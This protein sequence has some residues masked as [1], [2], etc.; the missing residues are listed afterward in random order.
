MNLLNTK[1]LASLWGGILVLAI[2]GLVPPWR[3]ATG[4]GNPLSYAPIFTPPSL[5]TAGGVTVDYARLL[6]EWLITAVITGGLLASFQKVNEGAAA[7]LA[8]R[9]NAAQPAAGVPFP[10]VTTVNSSSESVIESPTVATAKT[11]ESKSQP[12]AA[13]SE[14]ARKNGSVREL[15]TVRT[16]TFPSE[17]L[18]YLLVESEDDDEYWE[19]FAQA[20]GKVAVPFGSRIQLELAQSA[21]GNISHLD[22]LPSDAF[23]SL[24]FS[25]SSLSDEGLKHIE[26][27][28]ELRELDLS[29]TSVTDLGIK[30]LSGLSKL[31]KVWLDNTRVTDKGLEELANHRELEKVSLIGTRI[32]GPAAQSLLKVFPGKCALV[33]EEND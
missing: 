17:S 11:A 30:S 8:A 22:T 1:Q 33:L 4:A 27:F 3:D 10:G 26:H 6:I 31:K 29:D 15:K 25:G 2:L 32:D 13:T 16:L 28:S 18:G 23:Y 12:D 24:D 9:A 5:Q 14:K 7:G 19:V 21:A 20:V